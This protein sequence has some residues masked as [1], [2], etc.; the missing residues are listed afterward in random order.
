MDNVKAGKFL[1]SV[2][3]ILGAFINVRVNPGT[4]CEDWDSFGNIP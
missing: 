1:K 4:F 3:I 2:L